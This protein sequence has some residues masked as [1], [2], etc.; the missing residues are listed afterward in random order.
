MTL[1][2]AF[3]LFLFVMPTIFAMSMSTAVS[4]STISKH[5]T[6][7][8]AGYF[9]ETKCRLNTPGCPSTLVR[10]LATW[11]VPTVT[12]TESGEIF[13][14]SMGVAYE[15][16]VTSAGS[17]LYVTCT[18]TTA[19][20]SFG[21]SLAGSGGGLGADTISPGD[22]MVTNGSLVPSTGAVSVEIKDITKGW[23][24]GPVKGTD[25]VSTAYTGGAVF[26]ICG[27]PA[28]SGCA[29]STTTPL[30]KFTTI[31][32][33][34]VKLTMGGHSG[35]PGSFLSISGISTTEEIWVNLA[36]YGGTGHVVAEPT[37]ISSTSTG[38]SIKWIQGL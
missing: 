38:F 32:F 18:G 2:T 21:Y 3:L 12:C 36:K 15:Y 34:S 14:F 27:T 4:S 23:T 20:Y 30:P 24:Y 28:P 22:K 25:T 33:T 17:E 11:N 26:L 13:E 1:L 31:K 10:V 16:G 19:S 6:Q 8:E 37:S 5:T 7:F 9:I 29:G 35:T